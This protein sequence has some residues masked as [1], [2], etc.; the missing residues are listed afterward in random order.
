MTNGTPGAFDDCTLVRLALWDG[1]LEG[2]SPPLASA[3]PALVAGLEIL[4]ICRIDLKRFGHRRISSNR[5]TG[6]QLA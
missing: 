2:E 6:N 5:N 3:T 1:L 4:R